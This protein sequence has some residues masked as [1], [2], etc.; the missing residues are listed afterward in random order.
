MFCKDVNNVLNIS[1]IIMNLAIEAGDIVIDAT[2]GNG[3][4]TIYMAKL[5]GDKGKVYGF[6]IQNTAINITK[7]KL[8]KAGFYDR[9]ILINSGHEKVDIY[10]K[11]KVK[12]VVF[13]LGFLPGSDKTIKTQPNTTII[14]IEKSLDL[15]MNNG[16]LLVISYTGHEGGL[17]EKNAV[18]N[19]LK[20]LNQKEYNVFKFQF[21]NQINNPPILFGVEKRSFEEG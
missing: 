17:E 14:G 19:Y 12:L 15:L 10:I 3:N 16:V 20:K 6:D 11:E 8:Q 2:I 13:N 5:V 7:Q 21:I 1:K 9:V 18:E 4:D